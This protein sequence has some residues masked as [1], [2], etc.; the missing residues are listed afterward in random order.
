MHSGL[1]CSPQWG[2]SCKQGLFFPF[3]VFLFV[4]LF[5][6]YRPFLESYWICNNI[7]SVFKF[8]F[9]GHKACGI[10]V[11]HLGI[12]PTPPALEGK[13]FTTGPPRKSQAFFYLDV[14]KCYSITL[15]STLLSKL[16]LAYISNIDLLFYFLF[17]LSFN[18][19]S[20]TFFQGMQ[21]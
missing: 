16:V 15:V 12:E 3:K 19:Y 10:L 2:E 5:F 6:W 20:L 7:A 21:W 14:K 4:C 17:F 11:S 13:V 9:F 18:K 1:P 8:W